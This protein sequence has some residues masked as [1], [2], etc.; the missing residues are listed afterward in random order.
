MSLTPYSSPKT[1]SITNAANHDS[2]TS[3][4]NVSRLTSTSITNT[5]NTDTTAIKTNSSNNSE[6]TFASE[7]YAEVLS[8]TSRINHIKDYEFIVQYD[9]ARELN[10]IQKNI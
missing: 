4:T 7:I 2:K 1:T 3:K 9:E 6:N 5:A 10:T 8:G